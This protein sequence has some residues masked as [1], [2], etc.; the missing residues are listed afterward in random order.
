[1]KSRDKYFQTGPW[2]LCHRD[3]LF[4]TGETSMASGY[5]KWW[6]HSISAAV[7]FG[8]IADVY[9]AANGLTRLRSAR[10]RKVLND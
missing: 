6:T 10:P 7:K 3:I 1:M 8:S 2:V 4:W 5:R 9:Q